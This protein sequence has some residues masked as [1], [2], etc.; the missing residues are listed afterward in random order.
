MLFYEYINLPKN[1]V[2]RFVDA[3]MRLDEELADEVLN[4]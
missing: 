1:F 3:I 2:I 4:P